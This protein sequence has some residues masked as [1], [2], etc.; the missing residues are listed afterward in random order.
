MTHI[1]SKSGLDT[2]SDPP[3]QTPSMGLNKQWRVLSQW[4]TVEPLKTKYYTLGWKFTLLELLSSLDSHQ[5]QEAGA[6]SL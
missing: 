5:G 1:A 4:D 2:R 3:R 6:P